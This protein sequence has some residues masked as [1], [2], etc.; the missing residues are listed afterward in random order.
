MLAADLTVVHNANGGRR[1]RGDARAT[2]RQCKRDNRADKDNRD[3]DAD[4][5]NLL[6]FEFDHE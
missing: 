6:L 5:L 3:E 2:L 1:R 4:N